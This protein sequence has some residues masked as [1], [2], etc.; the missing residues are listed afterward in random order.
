[1]KEEEKRRKGRIEKK[2]VY[3]N[4]SGENVKIGNVLEMS[5]RL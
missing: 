4:E 1:M 5:D 2:I 3:K